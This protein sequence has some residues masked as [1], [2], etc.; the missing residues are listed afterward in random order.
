MKRLLS[1]FD[2]TGKWSEPYRMNQWEVFRIDQQLGFNLFDWNYRA[3]PQDYFD[4]I[5][6]AEPC[7]D[8]ALSGA[9]HFK[10]KDSDGSTYE[11]MSLT[12]KSLSIVQYFTGKTFWS[13]ENPMS[14]IHKLVPELGKVQFKFHPYEFAGYDPIERNSQ[15]QKTTWL[16]GD[17]NIPVKMERENLDGQK[18]HTDFGGKSLK[19]KNERSKTPLGFAYAFYHVNNC[20]NKTAR[21][22][23]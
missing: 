20:S 23:A 4:G 1:I 17:F 15:Y 19:T 22:I 14:R 6:I 13:L 11:S 5:L 18:Y 12:Y 9:K 2:L 7:T 10:R 8:F 16:W 3:L 21:L